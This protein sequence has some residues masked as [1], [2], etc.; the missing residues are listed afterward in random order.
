MEDKDMGKAS[1]YTLGKNKI[2]IYKYK[3]DMSAVNLWLVESNGGACVL[4][5]AMGNQ[6]ICPIPAITKHEECYHVN[7][8][9][10]GYRPIQCPQVFRLVNA[11]IDKYGKVHDR[12]ETQK[13]HEDVELW[14]KVKRY[15]SKARMLRIGQL[16]IINDK[17]VYTVTPETTEIKIPPIV[18]NL[19][20]LARQPYCRDIE[21]IT[22][23]GNATSLPTIFAAMSKVREVKLNEGLTSIG[24]RAFY[25][26]T[27]LEEINIPST[28]KRIGRDAFVSCRNMTNVKFNGPLLYLGPGAFSSCSS[29]EEIVLPNGLEEIQNNTFLDCGK[30]KKVFIPKSVQS[31]SATAF[32]R[33]SRQIEVTAPEHLRHNLQAKMW[34]GLRVKFY[35]G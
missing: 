8:G 27:E 2:E 11:R 33:T 13:Y 32:G 18:K 9:L 14:N 22:I 17:V 31:V 24:N 10:R 1:R 35:P 25:Y 34:Y 20:V 21:K 16:N 12:R 19:P 3:L 7:R 28:V 26:C 30:L 23:Q 5:D 15:N 6:Y 29:L 4:D